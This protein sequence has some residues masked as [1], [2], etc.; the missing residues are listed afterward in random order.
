MKENLNF[1]LKKG[2]ALHG[3]VCAGIV[4]GTRLTLAAMRHWG[5]TLPSEIKI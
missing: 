5:W 1:Y 2:E 4:L 3:D